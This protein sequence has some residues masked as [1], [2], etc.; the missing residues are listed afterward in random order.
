MFH[1]HLTRVGLV[2]GNLLGY[3]RRQGARGEDLEQGQAKPK[4][5]GRFKGMIL[6]KL[7]GKTLADILGSKRSGVQDVHYLR[8]ALLQVTT[9]P[10]TDWPFQL[11][12]TAI[13]RLIAR[14]PQSLPYG[15]RMFLCIID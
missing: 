5:Q 9:P 11:I 3:S 10:I 14:W 12:Y 7:S 13:S 2:K 1:Y 4:M 6:Q 8:A 15:A